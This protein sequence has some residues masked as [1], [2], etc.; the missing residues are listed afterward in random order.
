VNQSNDYI[1][2]VN[3]ELLANLCTV[4]CGILEILHRCIFLAQHH[5]N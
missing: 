2:A 1:R 3:L 5:S 4:K